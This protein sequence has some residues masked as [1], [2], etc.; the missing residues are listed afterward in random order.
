MVS[1]HLLEGEAS[2][3]QPDGERNF[4]R[5]ILR[6]LQLLRC[7]HYSYLDHRVNHFG[8][9]LAKILGRIFAST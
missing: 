2:G 6:M 5:A 9:N 1:Q 7:G 3:L 8:S 4:C